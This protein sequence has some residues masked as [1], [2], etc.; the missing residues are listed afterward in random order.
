[1]AKA[2]RLMD[3]KIIGHHILA[4][5]RMLTDEEFRGYKVRYCPENEEVYKRVAA[6]IQTINDRLAAEEQAS[7]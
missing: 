7:V 2:R 4:D 5:G 3:D 6:V 1:M